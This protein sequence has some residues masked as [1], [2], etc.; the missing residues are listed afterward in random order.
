MAKT[1]LRF[2][3]LIRVSTEKQEKKGESLKTQADDNRASVAQIGGQIVGSY[4][5]Q[6][7]ATPGFEKKEIDRLLGDARKHK[8][9]AVVV[10]NADR[11]S[12][13]NSK[14]IEG[15]DLFR[16]S[17][18]RFFVGTTEQDLFNPEHCLFLGM[19]A[20]IGQFQAQHQSRKSLVNRISRAKQG[21]PTGGKLPFGRTY[22]NGKWGVD[23]K[24]Q[25]L[26]KDAAKRYLGGESMAT[27]AAEYG[28][29]HSSLHKT[30][31]QRC[32]T[33][34]SVTFR[35]DA[36]NINEVV[37]VTVP[38]LLP[39]ET[40]AAIRKRIAG[41]K[42][43]HHGQAKHAYLLGRMVFC[44][45][46]GYA[47]FGQTNHNGHRYYRHAHTRRVTECTSPKAWVNADDL[48][49]AV[50]RYLFEC[51]GN[52][53]AIQRAV[54]QATP[55]I[56]TV[57]A[58]RERQVRLQDGL[59]KNKEA[60]AKVLRLLKRELLPEDE[61][62]KELSAIKELEHRQR[63]ELDRILDELQ[64][65]ATPESIQAAAEMASA[66]F[67]KYADIDLAMAKRRANRSLDAMSWE[68]RRA[69]VELVFAGQMTDGK[70][71]GVYIEWMEGQVARRRKQW[72]FTMNGHLIHD[73][74]YI[75]LSHDCFVF[76][77]P[78]LQNALVTKTA[79][80]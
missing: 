46:C 8:F 42:T 58:Y 6:E 10:S 75:P 77:A 70:R 38:R 12:R 50:M 66:S 59:A 36:L 16:K 80:C 71:M 65:V 67:R 14:S 5:G 41:N 20:V 2:A 17:R 63:Q 13:D 29:N 37:S 9:D 73:W 55:N 54:T 49:D 33:E 43:Y 39:E 57:S 3:S 11:W 60:R 51:F 25:S 1:K 61:A 32:G 69:L 4:G 72:K 34:W 35:S 40:I 15:L 52:P 79:S 7:H 23:P 27:L 74:S 30:L 48:E 24:K 18:I 31:T 45:H 78:H 64:N 21:I 76:G 53:L 62:E 44:S 22:A 19:S 28:V 26:I 68:D 47:M 56:E